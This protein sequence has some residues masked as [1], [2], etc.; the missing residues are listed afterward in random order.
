MGIVVAL[1]LAVIVVRVNWAGIALRNNQAESAFSI[2]P[3]SAAAAAQSA[4]NALQKNDL[5][6]AKALAVRAIEL[7]GQQSQALRVLAQVAERNGQAD[8]AATAI[9]LAAR[10]GWRDGFAQERVL[11]R[12]LETK[13]L[14]T[15]AL[16]ADAL[17]RTGFHS[18][19]AEQAL[20]RLIATEDGRA[21]FVRRLVDRPA[22]APRFFRAFR[23]ADTQDA[24]NLGALIV[25]SAKAG[26]RPPRDAVA[27]MFG[28]LLSNGKLVETVQIWRGAA[29]NVPGDPREGIV[30]GGFDG[31][32]SADLAGWGPFGWSVGENQWVAISTPW[33]NDLSNDP[34]LQ[35]AATG[36]REVVAA[37]QTLLL[38]PGR[39]ALRYEV[40]LTEG[41]R[42]GFNW[43]LN[44]GNDSGTVIMKAPVRSTS[45]PGWTT[46]TIV[47]DVP[48]SGCTAQ[49]LTLRTARTRSSAT[50]QLDNVQIAGR[51]P[52]V[53]D[54]GA[55]Q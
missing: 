44:C 37:R 7:S 32:S 54:I 49:S 42:A 48:A 4:E 53:P 6:R 10:L 25:G 8:V 15:A 27:P 13:D 2:W 23:P 12:A 31:L 39:H 9:I 14:G 41:S 16:A 5:L 3:G 46:E 55:I 38:P 33:R 24:T 19:V 18:D 51:A 22:W 40:S 29:G 17:L 35:I 45:A 52:V 47:F 28:Y 20:H 34:V 50:I 1:A 43:R 36:D 30:D 21:A 26:V 11:N